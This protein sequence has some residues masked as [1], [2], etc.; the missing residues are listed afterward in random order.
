MTLNPDAAFSRGDILREVAQLKRDVRTLQTARRLEAASIGAGGL[1]VK[2]GQIVIL[3]AG[4]N[5][6]M[7]LSTDGLSLEGL[8][9]VTGDGGVLRAADVGSNR[10]VLTQAGGL[11]FGTV[12]PSAA[13]AFMR[14]SP[15]FD[16]LQFES[17]NFSVLSDG[18]IF[19]QATGDSSMSLTTNAEIG[20]SVDTRYVAS[21]TGT[22]FVQAEGQIQLISGADQVFISHGTGTGTNAVWSVGS[23]L[24]VAETSARRFKTDIRDF[25]P[26]SRSIFDLKPRTWRDRGEVEKY[27][28]TDR[29]QIGY[30]AEELDDIGLGAFVNY[31]EDGAPFSI[32]YDR[33]VMPAIEEIKTLRRQVDSLTAWAV[34][35]GY[36]SPET[37]NIEMTVLPKRMPDHSRPTPAARPELKLP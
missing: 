35:Q 27:A 21:V 29:W 31:D 6:T 3:D 8:L 4:G 17:N 34:I 5:E 26:P 14:W 13:L 2:G 15:V 23:D 20:V 9:E 30:V 16:S 37:P 1:T 32:A 24:L 33:L 12:S 18:Q 10:Y 22:S 7:R 28:D 36:Q 11:E 19:L 25:H